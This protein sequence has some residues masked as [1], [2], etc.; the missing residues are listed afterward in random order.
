M[1][2]KEQFARA[3][4]FRPAPPKATGQ[5]KAIFCELDT[6]ETRGNCAELT[7]QRLLGLLLGTGWPIAD[8]RLTIP[9]TFAGRISASVPFSFLKWRIGEE[10]RYQQRICSERRTLTTLDIPPSQKWSPWTSPVVVVGSPGV[11]TIAMGKPEIPV[12]K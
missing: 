11:P 9:E 1:Y 2:F 6:L 5:K 10:S 12:G 8:Q 3:L 7:P 4:P